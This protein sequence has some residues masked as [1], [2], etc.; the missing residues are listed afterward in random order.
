MTIFTLAV[1]V[2]EGAVPP[3]ANLGPP[4]ISETVRARKLKFYRHLD[5]LLTC[6]SDGNLVDRL[7]MNGFTAAA[8]NVAGCV[9]GLNCPITG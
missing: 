7:T 8:G 9:H 2:E 5:R 3:S 1:C 6:T 4:Y